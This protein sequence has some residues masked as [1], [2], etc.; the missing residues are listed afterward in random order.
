MAGITVGTTSP[1][2]N[3][4]SG[5]TGTAQ[6][7]AEALRKKREA[8][9]AAQQDEQ[10]QRQQTQQRAATTN[11]ASAGY[12]SGAP[13]AGA[14]SAAARQAANTSNVTGAGFSVDPQGYTSFNDAAAQAR[15]T[16]AEADARRLA[17]LRSLM[18]Q[19]GG[20]VGR[21]DA[22]GREQHRG[23]S[24]GGDEAAARAA[25]FARAKDQA[26]LVTRSAVDSLRDLYAGTGNVGAQREGLENIVA[27]GAGTLNEFTR[28]QLMSDL[29]REGEVSDMTYQGGIVQRGQDINRPFNPQLQALISL[30]GTLY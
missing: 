22:P 6:Q 10:F 18:S 4:Q 2:Y 7:H 13:S 26:G 20:P 8:D 16:A 3:P 17:T 19:Y 12:A 11:A 28:D 23:L 5:I 14:A 30:M 29:A 24:V 15:R 21:A 1:Y 25:A 9:A 27:G